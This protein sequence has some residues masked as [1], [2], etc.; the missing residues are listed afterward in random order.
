[1]ISLLDTTPAAWGLAN[2]G[3]QGKAK[4]GARQNKLTLETFHLNIEVT[5]MLLMYVWN[6]LGDLKKPRN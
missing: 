5:K 3:E 2:G 4:I 1:M 6:A